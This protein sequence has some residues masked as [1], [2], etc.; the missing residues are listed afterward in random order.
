MVLGAVIYLGFALLAITEGGPGIAPD[1]AANLL[2]AIVLGWNILVPIAMI[3][4]IIDSVKK[5]RAG[6]TRELA[7]GVFVVK[8]A[9]IPLFLLNFALLALL[10]FGGAATSMRGFGIAIL[11]VAAI[12]I[13]LDYLTMLSTSVYGW[14]SVIRLRRERRISTKLAVLYTI[15]LFVFVAD[16]VVGIILFVHYRRGKT[17]I[18]AEQS[19]SIESGVAVS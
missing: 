1:D 17:A 7:T 3:L 10:T 4:A 2:L 6:K 11:A 18:V 9:A 19:A 15:L 12:L 5:T 14:A 16:T 8:V 13:C